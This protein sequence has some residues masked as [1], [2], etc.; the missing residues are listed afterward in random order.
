MALGPENVKTIAQNL[1]EGMYMGE[2]QSIAEMI[3]TDTQ[4]KFKDRIP[5]HFNRK[6]MARV[7]CPISR[8]SDLDALLQRI[9]FEAKTAVFEDAKG[10]EVAV[11]YDLLVGA[12]GYSSLVRREMEKLDDS[13]VRKQYRCKRGYKSLR[14]LPLLDGSAWLLPGL[15]HDSAALSCRCGV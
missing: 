15:R 4:D 2:R 11:S 8:T 13:V 9:D 3:L 5:F 7:D 10:E 14:N 6:C 1:P 12:D